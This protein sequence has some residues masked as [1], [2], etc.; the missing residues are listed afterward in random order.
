MKP[1]APCD[2]AI[3]AGGD[4]WRSRRGDGLARSPTQPDG[5]IILKERSPATFSGGHRFSAIG[6]LIMTTNEYQHLWG[7]V[8]RDVSWPCTDQLH[9]MFTDTG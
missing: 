2:G 1:E 7:R 4:F 3:V 8:K 5:R 9:L 6:L